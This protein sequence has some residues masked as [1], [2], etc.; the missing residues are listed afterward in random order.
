V[1]DGEPIAKTDDAISDPD[2]RSLA[3]PI[4]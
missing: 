4:Q 1:R 3:R 2:S